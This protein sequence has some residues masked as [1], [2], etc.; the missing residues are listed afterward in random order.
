M[1]KLSKGKSNFDTVL[2]SQNCVFGNVRLS[3]NPQSKKIGVS[4]PFSTFCE[5]QSVVSCFFCMEKG[6]SVRFCRVRKFYVPRGILKWVPKNSNNPKASMIQLMP[7]HPNL[8]WDQILLLDLVFL[9]E[10]LRA[11]IVLT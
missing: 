1:D 2:S 11:K 8:L 9:Q 7:M 5:K 10:L 4:K 3:F 6:H